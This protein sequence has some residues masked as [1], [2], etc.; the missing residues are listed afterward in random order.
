M[1][2][3]SITTTDLESNVRRYSRSCPT[4]FTRAQGSVVSAEG[5]REYLDFFAGAGALNYRHN[6]PEL[7]KTVIEHFTDDRVI[8]SL[9]MFT[10]VRRTFLETF[11]SQIL[12]PRE[13]DYRMIFPGPAGNNEIGRAS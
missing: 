12:E 13:L 8:H 4:A 11:K 5:G 3:P 9:D 7:K 6:H 2:A 1:T 10:D